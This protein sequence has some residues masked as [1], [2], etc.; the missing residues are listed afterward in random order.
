MMFQ[1]TVVAVAWGQINTDRF[2]GI[3]VIFFQSSKCV[4]LTDGFA[5]SAKP[6]P[7]PLTSLGRRRRPLPVVAGV[8]GIIVKATEIPF[9]PGAVGID[10]TVGKKSV[11]PPT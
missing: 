9:R 1:V 10:K 5:V 4:V 6:P 7:E 2:P 11:F 8:V 3:V